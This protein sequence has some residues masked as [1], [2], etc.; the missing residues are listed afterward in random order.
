MRKL[1]TAVLSIAPVAAFILA[2]GVAPARAQDATPTDSELGLTQPVDRAA[3]PV[4]PF[5]DVPPGSPFE[6]FVNW[7]VGRGFT[8]GCGPNLFCPNDPVTRGQISVFLK[9]NSTTGSPLAFG[10]IE[11]NGTKA[12]GSA[13]VT[14]T[15]DATNIRY[16][17]A[18]AN[19]SYFFNAYTTIVTLVSCPGASV[20]TD[21]AG[22]NLLVII[23]NAGNTANIACR[24]QFTTDYNGI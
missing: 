6:P 23:R 17:I 2:V 19:H 13:N 11:A 24:F 1:S 21:S 4:Q 9:V 18:I 14:S 15:F 12:S 20:N 16:N 3:G 7:L 8:S 22:G 5:A 10:F